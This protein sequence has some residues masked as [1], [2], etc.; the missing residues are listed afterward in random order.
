MGES[1]VQQ[2]SGGRKVRT[3]GEPNSM[4]VRAIMGMVLLAAVLCPAAGTASAGP[5]SLGARNTFTAARNG[6]VDLVLSQDVDLPLKARTH[7]EG[8]PA[9]WITF[10]GGGRVA[11][12]V[13]MPRGSADVSRGLVATQ[14]RS[15]PRQCNEQPVNALM[16][17]GVSYHGSETLPAGEY[18]VYAITDGDELTI[19]LNLPQLSGRTA[20]AIGRPR[21][22]DTQTPATRIEHRDGATTL[23]ASAGYEMKGHGG[24]FMAV[25]VMRDENYR[26]V[27]FDECLSPDHA[28]PDELERDYCSFPTGG[29]QFMRP[30]DPTKIE[31][32]K[33]GFILTTFVAL[34]D[35]L[36]SVFNG[37]SSLQHYSFRVISPG[38]VAELWSQA[39]L[40]SY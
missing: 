23:A 21:F 14:F 19:S 18:R 38:S 2:S 5:P 35:R 11:G 6:S 1:T 25:N 10:E 33:G 28:V 20:I 37:D 7:A 13:L 39:V 30:L 22:A 9:P 31:P 16:I 3:K 12:L 4:V 26:D 29:F 32:R 34:N 8:G 15:C 24:I 27:S 17:N 36:D 40:L